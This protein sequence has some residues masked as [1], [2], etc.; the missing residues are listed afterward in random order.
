MSNVCFDNSLN[1]WDY[2]G[3]SD[4]RI[5]WHFAWRLSHGRQGDRGE[6]GAA[7]QGDA[8]CWV[9]WA[10]MNNWLKSKL[11][12]PT[13]GYVWHEPSIVVLVPSFDPRIEGTW[14]NKLAAQYKTRCQLLPIWAYQLPPAQPKVLP[15]LC[16]FNNLFTMSLHCFNYYMGV[17]IDGGTPQWLV[18][19]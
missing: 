7:D 16:G 11:P 12:E 18:D 9:C 1:T 14:R 5:Y 4:R 3:P 10:W 15:Q 19:N 6:W 13:V 2:S 8:I 17:S